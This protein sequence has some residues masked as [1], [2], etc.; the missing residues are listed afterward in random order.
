MIAPPAPPGPAGP[1]VRPEVRVLF[2]A[3]RQ[4]RRRRR[5]AWAAGLACL[6]AA[7]LMSVIWAHFPSGS[8]A[9]G[10][11]VAQPPGAAGLAAPQVAWVDYG[12]HLHLANLA[13]HAQ[14]VLASIS[15]APDVQLA[16]AGGRIYWINPGGT[17]H[18][19]QDLNLATGRI[20]NLGFGQSVF[21]SAD[22][23]RVFVLEA[24][25]VSLAPGQESSPGSS[26][27]MPAGAGGGRPLTPPAGWYLPQGEDVLDA[28]V[29]VAGGF[30]VLSGQSQ[31][32]PRPAELAVWHWRTGRVTP[33]GRVPGADDGIIGAYT[34]PAASYSLVA[35][36]PAGCGA[37]CPVTIT[38]TA[39][40]ASVTVRSPLRFGFAL[41]G[42]FSPDGR[43]LALF[44]N[45][46]PG[47]GGQTAELALASP[48]TGALRL[49]PA[50]RV[51]LG[52]AVGWARWL[53]GGR[54]L[55]AGSAE[56]DYLIDAAAGSAR[57]LR[58]G[59]SASEP[60]NYSAVIVP[61]ADPADPAGRP[62]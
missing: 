6:L 56:R 48:S 51:F 20:Q 39:S 21:P 28:P 61:A 44:V 22:G 58:I 49:V 19:V 36:A 30:L 1:Q 26:T 45:R 4:R 41:G 29:A 59:P 55:I 24:N 43:E 14:R 32:R 23:K 54:Q 8:P 3:A 27:G 47:D 57:P 7:G 15:A 5:A 50:A 2:E 34:P 37:R 18:V 9:R 35:W 38:N 42:A 16:Q 46:A 31:Q 12:G 25:G 13:A 17:Y 62:R 10:P 40:L 33:I 53:P 52:Q 11:A 60:V